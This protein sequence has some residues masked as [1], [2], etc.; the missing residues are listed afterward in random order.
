MKKMLS[1]LLIL[2]SL[3]S[4]ITPAW[5]CEPV[6]PMAALYMGEFSLAIMAR[7]LPFLLVF[8]DHLRGRHEGAAGPSCIS[9]F[10]DFLVK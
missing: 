9:G 1:V 10:P 3:L 7:S 6:I 2:L 8:T 5:G 4:L